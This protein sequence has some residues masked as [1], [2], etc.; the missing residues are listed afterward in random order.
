MQN[1]KTVKEYVEM[2]ME[3]FKNY[4]QEVGFE[5]DF[6]ANNTTCEHCGEDVKVETDPF[7]DV[8][9]R[10]LYDNFQ[11]ELHRLIQAEMKKQQKNKIETPDAGNVV[12]LGQF[13]NKK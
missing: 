1:P 2:H 10:A 13:K 4:I 5:L 7:K 11:A 3:D 12:D 9:L 6:F 8:I